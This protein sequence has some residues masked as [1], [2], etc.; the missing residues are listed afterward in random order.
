[1]QLGNFKALAD[2]DYLTAAYSYKT[3]LPEALNINVLVAK[4]QVYASTRKC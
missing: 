3:K 1:M 4:P 2:S